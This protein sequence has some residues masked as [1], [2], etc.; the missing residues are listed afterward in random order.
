MRASPDKEP[1][2]EMLLWC[3]CVQELMLS[4]HGDLHDGIHYLVSTDFRRWV[5]WH[6]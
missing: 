5:K 1:S 4:L 3:V 6:E 2:L